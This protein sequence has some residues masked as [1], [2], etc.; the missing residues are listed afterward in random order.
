MK[1]FVYAY[2]NTI[3]VTITDVDSEDKAYNVLYHRLQE[4]QDIYEVSLPDIN[5][6]D[7]VTAY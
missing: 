3:T 1:T 4:I 2:N 7:L 6:F 5:C